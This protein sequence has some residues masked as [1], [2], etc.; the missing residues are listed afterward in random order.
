MRPA[1]LPDFLAVRRG[2]KEWVGTA[3]AA[4]VDDA[5]RAS[6]E[7]AA[8]ALG[9]QLSPWDARAFNFTVRICAESHRAYQIE[10]FSKSGRK[11]AG[12]MDVIA[13]LIAMVARKG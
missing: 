6:G 13:G 9:L 11:E 2:R 5:A 4:Q 8:Q 10:E 7:T 1:R 3:F 12:G